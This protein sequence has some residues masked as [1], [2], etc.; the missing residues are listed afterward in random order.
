MP[1]EQ[2]KFTP[3]AS[4]SVKV[5]ADSKVRGQHLS[6]GQV[7]ELPSQLAHELVIAGKGEIVKGKK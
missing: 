4:H 6:Q 7:V 3:G 2:I 1:V 5:L